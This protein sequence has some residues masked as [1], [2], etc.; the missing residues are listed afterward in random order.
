AMKAMMGAKEPFKEKNIKE[1]SKIEGVKEVEKGFSYINIS[2]NNI[3]EYRNKKCD[4]MMLN[5]MSSAIT[6]KNL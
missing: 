3:L 6:D 2:G 1:L 5:S 4:I